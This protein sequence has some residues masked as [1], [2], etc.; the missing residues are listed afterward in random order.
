[1]SMHAKGTLVALLGPDLNLDVQIHWAVRLASASKLDCFPLYMGN[2][3]SIWAEKKY[4]GG[5]QDA[6]EKSAKTYRVKLGNQWQA[7]IATE[8][9]A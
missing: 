6:V 9:V 3:A 1:M 7:L 2:V 8:Q 5:A 4:D